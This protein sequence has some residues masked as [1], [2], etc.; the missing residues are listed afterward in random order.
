MYRYTV[1]YSLNCVY[2]ETSNK[3]YTR[4]VNPKDSIYARQ[5]AKKPPNNAYDKY[6]PYWKMNKR[7]GK[8][9]AYCVFSP[10]MT[11]V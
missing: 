7:K 5:V 4:Q 3:T 10:K 6:L 9:S 2:D 1:I 11:W 8:T